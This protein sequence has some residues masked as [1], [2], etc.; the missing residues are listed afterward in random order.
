MKAENVNKNKDDLPQITIIVS[1][2]GE[3]V[4]T[5]EGMKSER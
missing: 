2:Q 1:H 5:L 4:F 3:S